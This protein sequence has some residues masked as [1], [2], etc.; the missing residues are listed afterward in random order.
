MLFRNKN[1][2]YNLDVSVLQIAFFVFKFSA[3]FSS[4]PWKQYHGIYMWTQMFSMCLWNNLN[5][6]NFNSIKFK[7]FNCGTCSRFTI[8]YCWVINWDYSHRGIWYLPHKLIFFKKFIE[9]C[10]FLNLLERDIIGSKIPDTQYTKFRIYPT[11][12]SL[13]VNKFFWRR[14]ESL[15]GRTRVILSSVIIFNI[16]S[17]P[18]YFNGILLP[19]AKN[20]D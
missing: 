14:R 9:S 2:A 11:E 8:I 7:K 12:S 3:Q 13:L 6:Y 19:T 5:A 10:K 15:S 4:V 20:I 18:N 16:W 1:F 17:W